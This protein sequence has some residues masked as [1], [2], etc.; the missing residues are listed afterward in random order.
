MNDGVNHAVPVTILYVSRESGGSNGQVLGAQ[1]NNWGLGYND[2]CNNWWYFGAS[3]G[4]NG[5][6]PDTSAHWYAATIQGSGST[7][8]VYANGAVIGTPAG[9]NSGPN[10][11][12][13]NG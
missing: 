8:T 13:L 5:S 7:T 3:E 9:N 10:N 2:G 4:G 11:L 12:E 6:G 1:D